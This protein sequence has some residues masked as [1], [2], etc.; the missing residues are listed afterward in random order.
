MQIGQT[1]EVGVL[2]GQVALVTGAAGGIGRATATM[3]V[4]AGARV[5]IVDI[6]KR[7]LAETAALLDGSAPEALALH[8]DVRQEEDMSTMADETLE[9][10]GRID[11]LIAAAGILRTGRPTT[12]AEMQPEEWDAVV[13][14][15]LRGVFLSNRAVLPAMMAQGRGHIINV[16]ST[17][18]REGR[19]FDSAYSASKAGV[20]GL[21]EAAA[22]EVRRYGIRV[23]AVLPGAV[24]TALW[25]QN[26]PI[27]RPEEILPAERIADLILFLLTMP[28]DTV[29]FEPVIVPFEARRARRGIR[30]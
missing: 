15:N 5:A 2:Q 23:N 29:L 8:L 4:G 9:R 13:D 16:A 12:L 24:D 3:L 22:Q 7:G 6:D 25:T 18:A 10:L 17:A 26:A 27:P 20:V 1:E 11:V 21:S 19:A 30:E 14:V 28:E